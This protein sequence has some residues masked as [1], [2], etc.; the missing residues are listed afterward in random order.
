MLSSLSDAQIADKIKTLAKEHNTTVPS[1]VTE[2]VQWAL[3]RSNFDVSKL[4]L[5][6]AKRRGRTPDVK[7]VVANLGKYSPS[8]LAE[9]QKAIEAAKHGDADNDNVGRP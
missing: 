4:E 7:K 1:L 3:T 6:E 9:L 2:I 5:Q 8:Q